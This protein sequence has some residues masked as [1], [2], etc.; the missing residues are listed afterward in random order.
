MEKPVNGLSGRE[1]ECLLWVA[2]GKTYAETAA[3]LD[4][5]FG[6]I[7]SNLD[8]ARYKLNCTTLPQAT[9]MAVAQGIFTPDDLKGR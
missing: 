6:T 1:R 4:L 9:A 5:A 2:R 7:K 8:H 3:I